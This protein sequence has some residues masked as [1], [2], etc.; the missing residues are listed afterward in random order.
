MRILLGGNVPSKHWLGE[1]REMLRFAAAFVCFS[2]GMIGSKRS[3]E[4]TH[5]HQG[6]LWCVL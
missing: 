5:L 3:R 4:G 1:P 6:H 2:L